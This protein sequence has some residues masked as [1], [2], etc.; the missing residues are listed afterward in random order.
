M[1]E[2]DRT[3]ARRQHVLAAIQEAEDPL[4]VAQI[5]ARVGV[6]LNTVRFHLAS[7]EADG[8][9]ER[10]LGEASGPGRPPVVYRARRGQALGEIRRYQMLAEILLSH[11]SANGDVAAAE[12]AGREWGAHL[13]D[14]PLPYHKVGVDEAITRLTKL[15]EDLDFAPEFV[16]S[17]ATAESPETP[18][19][20]RLRHC[21]FLELA[22]P[23]RSLVC[24]LHLGLMQGALTQL[25]APVTVT[26]LVPFAEPTACV[27][28][29][30]SG[31][32]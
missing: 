7:L 26:D 15:L 30:A 8:M 18:A 29:V 27:A 20:I 23:H 25:R 13:I 14:R 4:G 19:S 9:I 32:V 21:P 24:A 22:D 1:A 10:L 11:L 16:T 17:E 3:S 31:P 28:H 2:R 5:A 12:T 6:H